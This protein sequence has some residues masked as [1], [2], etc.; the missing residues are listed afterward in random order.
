MEESGR[1]GPGERQ[2]LCDAGLEVEWFDGIAHPDLFARFAEAIEA[3]PDDGAESLGRR[4]SEAFA[5][6]LER[7]GA[8]GALGAMGLGTENIVSVIYVP[9]IVAC[10][11]A[12]LAERDITFF[13]LH[14]MV[15]DEH[16]ATLRRISLEAADSPVRFERLRAG[17][18]AA[19]ELRAEVWDRLL[20]RALTALAALPEYA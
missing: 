1:Y 4:W 3:A 5:A 20:K 6:L 11:H 10:R 13:T 2:A 17:M 7:A 14:A 15:D 8:I 9:L 12:G 18:E 19:L 16:Q